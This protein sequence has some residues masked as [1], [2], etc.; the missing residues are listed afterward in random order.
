MITPRTIAALEAVFERSLRETSVPSDDSRIEIGRRTAFSGPVQEK[1]RLLVLTIS[2]YEFRI[3]VLFD[4]NLDAHT[5]SYFAQLFR[6]PEPRI[7][8]QALADAFSEYVNMICG[9][10][11]RLISSENRLTGMSTPFVLETSCKAHIQ[12]IHPEQTLI[13][14]VKI[15]DAMKFDLVLCLCVSNGARL[16]FEVDLGSQEQTVG[17]ELEMF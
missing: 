10:V 15:G 14:N 13:F 8:G 17:G 4:F 7:A 5:E 2:S 11:N 16:D 12:R 3:V 1:R 9:T 6:S